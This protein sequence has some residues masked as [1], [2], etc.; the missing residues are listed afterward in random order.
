MDCSNSKRLTN[1]ADKCYRQVMAKRIQRKRT[2]GWRMPDGCVYVGRPTK[3][4]NHYTILN[5]NRRN[6]VALYWHWLHMSPAGVRVAELARQ[7]LAGKDICC[8][9]REDKLCHGDALLCI[10][11]PDDVEF[12]ERFLAALHH[13]ESQ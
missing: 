1:L 10:A 11:N 12:R 6:A 8:W 2:S 9:C 3:Y 7:E 5:G 13:A 4:G